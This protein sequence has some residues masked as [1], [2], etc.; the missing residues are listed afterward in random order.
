MAQYQDLDTRGC[1][2]DDLTDEELE[3]LADIAKD[4]LVSHGE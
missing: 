3:D 2:P 1:M 4:Y